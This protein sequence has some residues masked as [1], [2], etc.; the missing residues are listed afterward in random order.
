MNLSDEILAL[1][2]LF[3]NDRLFLLPTGRQ[4]S[5]L[6]S[7]MNSAI[8]DSYRKPVLQLIT[9][10]PLINTATGLPS[11]KMMTRHMFSVLIN[12][13]LVSIEPGD[14]WEISDHYAEF[15]RECKNAIEASPGQKPWTIDPMGL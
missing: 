7:L 3:D 14:P 2:T 8:S 4:V 15:L 10:L 11:S 12:A 5:G 9:G 13:F 1:R 6:V